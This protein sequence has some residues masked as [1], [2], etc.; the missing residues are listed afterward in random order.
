MPTNNSQ[1]IVKYLRW[2][3]SQSLS[4]E[5]WLCKKLEISQKDLLQLL[6]LGA[7]YLDK[8]RIYYLPD[9]PTG[10]VFKVFLN[11]RRFCHISFSKKNLIFEDDRW[12]IVDKPGGLPSLPIAS[13]ALENALTLTEKMFQ[14]KLYPLH[15]LD[16]PTQGLLMFTKSKDLVKIY[17]QARKE[18]QIQKIYQV[19]T[20]NLLPLGELTHFLSR[21]KGKMQAHSE[22]LPGSKKAVLKIINS[23][24][25]SEKIYLSEIQLMTGRTHQIRCQL[26]H[27]QCPIIGDSLYGTTS[28][29][30]TQLKLLAQK[31]IWGDLAI[32]TQ[33]SDI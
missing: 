1:K 27:I 4:Q 2:E 15:R 10:E 3:N 9:A 28:S 12:V 16:E 11:P 22:E 14:I 30:D 20:Q 6:W 26:A 17:H 18:K 21:G 8:K 23:T 24:K 33:I 13:N 32:E 5:E 7:I 25:I 31:I 29:I 19:L